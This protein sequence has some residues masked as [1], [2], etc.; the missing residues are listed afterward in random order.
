MLGPTVGPF[1]SDNQFTPT[2]TL[3][4]GAGNVVPQYT[5]NVGKVFKVGSRVH[6]IIDLSGDGGAEGAGTGAITVALPYAAARTRNIGQVGM[7]QNGSTS[8]G[9]G[10]LG[11][12]LAAGT[13]TITLFVWSGANLSTISNVTGALQNNATRAIYLDF[14]YDV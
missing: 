6:C 7:I 13:S 3:V 12:T 4:G 14:W 11:G 1:E 5:V 8:G 9:V 2:V 10:V